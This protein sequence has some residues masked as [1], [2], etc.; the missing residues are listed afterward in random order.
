MED[1]V[2]NQARARFH[3]ISTFV[4]ETKQLLEEFYYASLPITMKITSESRHEQIYNE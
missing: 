4:T 2:A 1:R 3:V